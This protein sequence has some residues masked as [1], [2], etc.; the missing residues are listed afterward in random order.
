[1]EQLFTVAKIATA[2]QGEDDVAF[3]PFPGK[4]KVQFL[5]PC[6]HNLVSFLDDLNW[7]IWNTILRKKLSVKMPENSQNLGD[8]STSDMAHKWWNIVKLCKG[9]WFPLR[10]QR[11]IIFSTRL[12]KEREESHSL[13][14]FPLISIVKTYLALFSQLITDDGEFLS[15]FSCLKSKK[16]LNC[17]P[18]L[19]TDTGMR[20]KDFKHGICEWHMIHNYRSPLP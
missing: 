18:Q 14:H 8:C 12:L 17:G 10:L 5:D 15:S 9:N 3:K 2:A 1:M 6:L 20:L 13:P 11:L 19:K 4:R 16:S 7:S